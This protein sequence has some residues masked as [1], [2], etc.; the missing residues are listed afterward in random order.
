MKKS[1]LLTDNFHYHECHVIFLMMRSG[2]LINV[3]HHPLVDLFGRL[4]GVAGEELSDS[5]GAEH[6]APAVAGFPQTIGANQHNIAGAEGD[7][8]GRNK[9]GIIIDPQRITGGWQF[10][11]EVVAATVA[12][13][14]AMAGRISA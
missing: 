1:R 8:S 13:D 9:R 14:R 4:V 5:S 7:G 6:G 3:I 2:K 11:N 12:E 10:V